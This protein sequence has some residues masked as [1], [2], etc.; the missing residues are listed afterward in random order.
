MEGGFA[1]ILQANL[2]A[3]KDVRLVEREKLYV[4]LNEQKL[5]L[6]GLVDTQAATPTRSIEAAL[7]F[8][9]AATCYEVTQDFEQAKRYLQDRP[10]GARPE[11]VDAFRVLGLDTTAPRRFALRNRNGHHAEHSYG[12]VEELGDS[13]LT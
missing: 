12:A 13:A 10:V 5:T 2:S 7:H 4:V 9:N 8:A 3:L 1:D 11:L 6:A